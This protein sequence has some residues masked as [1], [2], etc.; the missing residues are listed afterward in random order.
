MTGPRLKLRFDEAI[1]FASEL[2]RHQ[3]RKG[4]EDI[5]YIAHLLA[6]TSLVIENHGSEDAV[7]AALL[8]DVVEDQ[9]GLPTLEKVTQRF[10]PRVAEIVMECSDNIGHPKPPWRVR[11]QEFIERIPTLSPEARLVAL[12]DKVHNARSIVNDLRRVGDTVWERFHGRRDGTLW[13]YREVLYAF[14]RGGDEPLLQELSRVINEMFTLA[15]E[16]NI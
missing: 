3:T 16:P 7:V 8:H 1:A 10:G 13:Y 6:V 11:K 4:G 14:R 15:G 5:P 9:G 12:A 2:H